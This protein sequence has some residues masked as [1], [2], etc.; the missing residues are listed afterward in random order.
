MSLKTYTEAD[1][2]LSSVRSELES[3]EAANSLLLGISMNLEWFPKRIETLPYLATVS[4]EKGLVLTALMTPP[5]NLTLSY[6]QGNLDEACQV[7]LNDLVTRNWAVPGIIA[8]V[9]VVQA[10]TQNWVKTTGKRSEAESQLILYELRKVRTLPAVEGHLRLAV[11]DDIEL[12]SQWGYAFNMEVFG[13]ADPSRARQAIELRIA[14]KDVYLWEDQT[15]CSM[16]MKT[17]P[18]RHG[19]SIGQV[20]TPPEFRGKGYATACVGNLSQR[21]LKSGW[22]FCALFADTTNLSANHIYQKIGYQPV[23]DFAV[24]SFL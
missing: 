6:H 2:F 4:D 16:A 23:S 11:Q 21:L 15:I 24:I 19:I 17:R 10:F 3:D 1:A 9:P 22:Q 5:H 7:L 8:P 12:V 20:Y 14:D 13:V 18:T